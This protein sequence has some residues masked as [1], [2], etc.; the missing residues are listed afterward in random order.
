[1]VDIEPERTAEPEA[2]RSVLTAAFDDV[3]EAELVAVL[4]EDGDLRGDCSVIARD[5]AVVGYAA[6]SDVEV[7]AAPGAV[8][9]VLGPVAV[10]PERQGE[11]IGSKLVR[12]AL[13]QCVRAGCAGVVLEGDPAF[14]ERFGF[15]PADAY[16][17][18]SDLDPPPGTFQVWPARPGSLDGIEGAVVHPAP[19]HALDEV[20]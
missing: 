17:L 16:G 6:V 14:Y 18:Q 7:P 3:T 13:T 5:D 4:R 15:E 20:R 1:V 11:G 8:L 2:I 9:A 10:V 12:T 19:F